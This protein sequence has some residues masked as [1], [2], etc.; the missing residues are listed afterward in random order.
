MAV[1]NVTYKEPKGYFSASM[2]KE[3]KKWEAEQKTKQ[4]ASDKKKK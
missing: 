2:L 4:K 3:A 1:K